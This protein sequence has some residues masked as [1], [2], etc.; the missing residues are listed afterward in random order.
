MGVRFGITT[1]APRVNPNSRPRNVFN[2]AKAVVAGMFARGHASRASANHLVRHFLTRRRL[3]AI[4]RLGPRGQI[5][6][7][8]RRMTKIGPNADHVEIQLGEQFDVVGQVIKGLTRNADHHAA[9]DFVAQLPQLFENRRAVGA[10]FRPRRMDSIEQRAIRGLEPQKVTVGPSAPPCSQLVIV[11]FA[12]AERNRQRCLRFD[13]LDKLG[14][15][16][17]GQLGVFARLKKQPSP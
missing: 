7:G 15:S 5:A 12:Q 17:A 4:G 2:V 1:L 11:A 6:Q 13:S 14:N 16:Q 3:F 10:P 9:A 8:S